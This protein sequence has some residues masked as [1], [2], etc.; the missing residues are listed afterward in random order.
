MIPDL[1]WTDGRAVSLGQQS[2]AGHP[3]YVNSLLNI[4]QV[5]DL[6]WDGRSTSLEDQAIN[7]MATMHEMNQEPP[8]IPAELGGHSRIS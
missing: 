7:P 3:Q 2:P 8:T 4:A 1:A 6:F 5:K